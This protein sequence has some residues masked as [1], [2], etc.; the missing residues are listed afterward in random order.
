MQDII[1]TI[2]SLLNEHEVVIMKN[3]N[4]YYNNLLS[5][6]NKLHIFNYKFLTINIISYFNI[7]IFDE[8][9]FTKTTEFGNLDN[10]KWLKENNCPWDSWT[11]KY[12]AL[13]GNLENMKWLH[14]N[15]CPWNSN[16]FNNDAQF[17][18]LEN[19]K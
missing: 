5:N 17:A 19:M 18:N 8:Y 14:L 12:A 11:F 9:S 13:L 6:C 3:V 15:N 10:M 2:L 16:T 4:K 1:S 7:A